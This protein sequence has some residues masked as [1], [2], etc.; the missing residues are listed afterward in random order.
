MKKLIVLLI[1]TFLSFGIKAQSFIGAWESY[2]TS[3]NGEKLKS[4]VIFS[5]GYQVITT[6]DSKTGKFISTNGGTWKL[7][8]NKM[9]TILWR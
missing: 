1:C 5:D 8:G 3:E 6:S 4:V 2:H 9:T 7:E